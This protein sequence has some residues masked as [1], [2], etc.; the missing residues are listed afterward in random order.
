M[1]R[2]TKICSSTLK[3]WVLRTWIWFCLF[4]FHLIS[5]P[6]VF[7]NDLTC[8]N[9]ETS[10]QTEWKKSFH[11]KNENIRKRSMLGWRWKSVHDFKGDERRFCNVCSYTVKREVKKTLR[12]K[13]WIE[14][15][16]HHQLHYDEKKRKNN[17]FMCEKRYFI[18]SSW[19]GRDILCTSGF[20]LWNFMS[21][22]WVENFV[23]F[24]N[25]KSR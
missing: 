16:Y 17:F 22:I 18:T 25:V 23:H 15:F 10:M 21:F 3:L 9:H 14:G 7:L 24:Q 5:F 2:A 4:I 8:F 19:F 12:V 1:T 6:L 13:Q 20:S 11:E